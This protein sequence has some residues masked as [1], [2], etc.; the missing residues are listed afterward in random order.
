VSKAQIT[1]TPP[2]PTHPHPPL[3]LL[4]LLPH[5]P[6]HNLNN[7]NNRSDDTH[8]IAARK[9][10]KMEDLRKAFGFSKEHA[11]REGDAFDQELQGQLKE[12][13]RIEHEE[14]VKA[15]EE[16]VGGALHSRV[17]D[18]SHGQH[19]LSIKCCF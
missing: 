8:A 10:E 12:K 14:Q 17:S 2:T 13:R 9:A 7:N 1:S 6:P 11:S 18:W 3:T 16:K 5:L 4:R 15:T 19:W